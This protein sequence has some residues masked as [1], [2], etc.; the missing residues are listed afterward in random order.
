M[1]NNNFEEPQ[2]QIEVKFN[3]RWLK[4]RWAGESG[5]QT[6]TFNFDNKNRT[7]DFESYATFKQMVNDDGA[8]IED[9]GKRKSYR[10]FLG[11]YFRKAVGQVEFEATANDQ[12]HPY[13][14]D[15]IVGHFTSIGFR[16]V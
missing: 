13:D 14:V 10:D 7:T 11:L 6:Y 2:P 12:C 3:F 5:T 8:M 4:G 15:E 16:R 1:E 9:M